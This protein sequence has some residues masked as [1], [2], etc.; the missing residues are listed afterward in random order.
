MTKTVFLAETHCIHPRQ[1]SSPPWKNTQQ[2]QVRIER[3]AGGPDPPGKIQ[4]IWVSIGNK[5]LDPLEKVRPPG[6]CWTPSGTL[7]KII[8][9]FDINHFTSVR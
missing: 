2:L 1:N 5:Q 6:K 3:G 4:V 7:K 8:D 9:F